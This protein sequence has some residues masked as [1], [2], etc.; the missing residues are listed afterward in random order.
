MTTNKS[1]L[2]QLEKAK[3]NAKH[4]DK[5]IIILYENIDGTATFDGKIMTMQEA[6]GKSAALSAK[7][8]ILLIHCCY[9]REDETE[10]TLRIIEHNE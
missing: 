6:E 10:N 1:R 8:N 9:A 3:G 5:K 2:M 4:E 7:D